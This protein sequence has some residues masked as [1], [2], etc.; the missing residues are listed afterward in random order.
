VR[1]GENL[2]VGSSANGQRIKDNTPFLF[3]QGLW[4]SLLE[5]LDAKKVA[6]SHSI[7]LQGFLFHQFSRLQNG[8]ARGRQKGMGKYTMSLFTRYQSTILT[9]TVV[10]GQTVPTSEYHIVKTWQIV[11]GQT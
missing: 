8:F 5:I 11:G 10:V 9:A 2:S 7:A 1:L 6:L 3:K 4:Q